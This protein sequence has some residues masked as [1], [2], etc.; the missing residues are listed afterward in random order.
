VSTLVRI[1]TTDGR[2]ISGINYTLDATSITGASP[3]QLAAVMQ[4]GM[5]MGVYHIRTPN[6]WEYIPASQI[7]SVLSAQTGAP[8]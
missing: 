7:A 5:D 4:G 6:G 8:T 1:Q 3:A 2:I